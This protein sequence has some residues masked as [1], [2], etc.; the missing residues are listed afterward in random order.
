MLNILKDG[1]TYSNTNRIHLKHLD[2]RYINVTQ[3]DVLT[4]YIRMFHISV[5]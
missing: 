3:N 4:I 5:M 2:D 1:R